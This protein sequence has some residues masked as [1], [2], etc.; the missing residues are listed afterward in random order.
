MLSGL[1]E[2]KKKKPRRKQSYYSSRLSKAYYNLW[3]YKNKDIMPKYG[4]TEDS[5]KATYIIHLIENITIAF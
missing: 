4:S 3:A 2:K 5:M 1:L